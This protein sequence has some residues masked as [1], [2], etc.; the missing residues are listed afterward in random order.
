[1]NNKEGQEKSGLCPWCNGMAVAEGYWCLCRQ[2]ILWACWMLGQEVAKVG[3]LALWA[4][5]LLWDARGVEHGAAGMAGGHAQAEAAEAAGCVMEMGL[6]RACQEVAW[7]E[8]EMERYGQ[9]D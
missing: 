5:A 7:E 6:C 3:P 4:G 9:R 2:E 1:M 8:G